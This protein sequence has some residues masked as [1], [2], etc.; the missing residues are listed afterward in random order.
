MQSECRWGKIGCRVISTIFKLDG[1]SL[2]LSEAWRRRSTQAQHTRIQMHSSKVEEI[3]IQTKI[4]IKNRSLSPLWVQSNSMLI[5]CYNTKLIELIFSVTLKNYKENIFI[6]YSWYLKKSFQWIPPSISN[7][8]QPLD[9]RVSV[10]I[11]EL[12]YCVYFYCLWGC[13]CKSFLY[14]LLCETEQK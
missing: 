8:S 1:G 9:F 6:N 14:N 10:N 13:E 3:Y 5:P 2:S 4:W 7:E 12:C 11:S